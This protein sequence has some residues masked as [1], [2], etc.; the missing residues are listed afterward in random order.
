MISDAD[1]AQIEK[2]MLA[3]ID[4]AVRQALREPAPDAAALLE[5][6]YAAG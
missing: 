4:E 2:E 5:G 6:V 3:E 1:F